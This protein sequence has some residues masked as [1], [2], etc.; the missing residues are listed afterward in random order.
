M[1]FRNERFNLVERQP[2][3]RPAALATTTNYEKYKFNVLRLR[4]PQLPVKLWTA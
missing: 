3:Q 1:R 2:A 4:F